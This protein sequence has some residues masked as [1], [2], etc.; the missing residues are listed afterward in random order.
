MSIADKML[1]CVIKDGKTF[2]V[3]INCY[4]CI[5]IYLYVIYKIISIL[6]SRLTEE[7]SPFK[8]KKIEIIF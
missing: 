1:E 7:T 8:Q 3:I 2:D 6:N 4:L 5:K